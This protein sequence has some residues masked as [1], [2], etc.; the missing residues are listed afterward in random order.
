MPK[1]KLNVEASLS[2]LAWLCGKATVKFEMKKHSVIVKEIRC[3]QVTFRCL[4]QSM[5][6]KLFKKVELRWVLN[7]S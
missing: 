5:E 1:G 7:F 6:V 2:K 4:V 3:F